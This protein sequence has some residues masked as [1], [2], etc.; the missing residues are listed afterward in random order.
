[1]K[2]SVYIATTLDGFIARK[3]G[4]LD[5][6]PGSDG[7]V[8]P[9]L[10]GEDFGYAEFTS[11]VDVLIMGRNT[12]ELVLSFG[13]WPYGDKRVIVIS[14][15][16]KSLCDTLPSNVELR[17]C[18]VQELHAEMQQSGAKHL[19]ID[20]GKTI[21]S[22]LKAELITDLILARV[23]VLIG[24]GIPLFGSLNQDILL[25]H[26]TTQSFKNGFVQSHYQPKKP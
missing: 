20:G 4:S 6:L 24:E 15:T 8:D 7:E 25:H 16:L 10:E 18:S 5:W 1:M 13:E 14:S 23:P 12:Y 3:D 26:N 22:L 21:Q 19:Y 9:E 11:T 17:S 2:V